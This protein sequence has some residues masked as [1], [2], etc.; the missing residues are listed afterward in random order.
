MTEKII[1]FPFVHRFEDYHEGHHYA[2]FLARVLDCTVHWE[3]LAS[4]MDDW[5]RVYPFKF[6]I[7]GEES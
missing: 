2:L 7:P 1:K 3:E 4:S 6:F 5:P